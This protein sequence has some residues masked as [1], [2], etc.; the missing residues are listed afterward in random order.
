MTE[1]AFTCPIAVDGQVCGALIPARHWACRK[2]WLSMPTP[3]RC[4]A[5]RYRRGTREFDSMIERANQLLANDYSDL[6][7]PWRR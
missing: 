2:H 5:N 6:E 7:P 4:N 3:F 1:L